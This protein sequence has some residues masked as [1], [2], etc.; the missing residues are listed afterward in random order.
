MDA[1]AIH[2]LVQQVIYKVQG[3]IKSSLNIKIKKEESNINGSNDDDW[4][5]EI[6]AASEVS[7]AHEY[8]EEIEAA[9]KANNDDE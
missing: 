9:T 6:K 8:I 2:N 7:N 4:I 5:Y 1:C 3:P